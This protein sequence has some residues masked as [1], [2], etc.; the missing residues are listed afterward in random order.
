MQQI[1][2]EFGF[3]IEVLANAGEEYVSSHG[4]AGVV[5]EGDV[6]IAIHKSEGQSLEAFYKR[7]DEIVADSAKS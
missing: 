6:Y 7:A 5:G 4:Y 2:S 3:V 1:A